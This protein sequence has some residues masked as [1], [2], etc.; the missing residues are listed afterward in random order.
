MLRRITPSPRAEGQTVAA[1][2]QVFLV[3]LLLNLGVAAGKIAIG[4]MSGALAIT[5]DGFHSLVDALGNVVG[6][7]ALRFAAL[8]PDD[9]HPYGHRRFE[10]LA[11]L[12]IG[13]FLLLTAWE[14]GLGALERLRGRSLPTYSLLTFV[15]LILTL[16]INIAVNRYQVQQGRRLRSELLLADAANTGSDIVVTLSV[17]VS[18]LVL[19]TTGWAW[20]DSVT[21][22]IVVLLI[23]RAAWSILRSTGRVLVDTAPYAPAQLIALVK[24]VPQVEQVLRARSRGTPDAALIDIDARIAP[25]LP[26]HQTAAITADI[27][28]RLHAALNGVQE[29]EVHFVPADLSGRSMIEVAVLC[30]QELGLA[31]HEIHMNGSHALELHVEVP[32]GQTLAAAHNQATALEA[33]LRDRLPQLKEI[34]T[35]I[36]PTPPVSTVDSPAELPYGDH[37]R[38]IKQV[39]LAYLTAFFPLVD[40]HHLRVYDHAG[41]LALTLHVTLAPQMTIDAAHDLSERAE[42]LLRAELPVLKRVTIHT[43]PYTAPASPNT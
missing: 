34:I 43:E 14:I 39:A 13:T 19:L 5:A 11:A 40:W 22:L 3:T 10:T 17:I 32:A 6:L 41:H 21:A 15:V 26:A 35:H 27:R 36:E 9:D 18:T 2:Q 30:A 28:Q 20:I 33:L 31:A 37:E 7:V 4:L 16:L 8:P 1:V 12:M 23:V 24:D 29:V 42:A 38:Q 25:G